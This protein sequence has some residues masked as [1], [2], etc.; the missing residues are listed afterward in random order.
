[1]FINKYIFVMRK[2]RNVLKVKVN[3]RTV[4]NFKKKK[5][6]KRYKLIM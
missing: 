6:E 5:K 2:P 3:S 4:L 1:M